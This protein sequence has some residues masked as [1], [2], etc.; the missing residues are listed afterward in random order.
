MKIEPFTI[1]IEESALVDLRRRLE[2]TRFAEDFA[3]AGWEY[4]TNGDYLKELVAY[5]RD[6]YDWRKHEKEMNAW[7]HFRTVI[8][9]MPIHFMHIRGKGPKPI[10]LILSH[11]WPWSFWDFRKVIGPLSDPAAYGGDP[12]DAFDVVVPSL[13]GF[14]FSTPLSKTGINFTTTAD[15]WVK[16]M[17]G[18]GYERFATHGG[19]WGAFISAQLGHKYAD[20]L[21]GTHFTVMTPLDMFS[22]GSV[23]AEDYAPEEMARLQRNQLFMQTGISHLILQSQTPQS[24]A[25]AFNDSPVGLCSWL[26]QKRR[27]WSDCGGNVEACFSKD[28]LLTLVMI[29]WL[30]QCYGTSARYYYE[31]VHHPWQP[32]HDRMP[33]V[34][35]PVGVSVFANELVIQPRRWAERYYNLR[36]WTE[37]PTGGHFAAAEQPEAVIDDV[38]AFYRELR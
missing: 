17:N 25:Y 18:L 36:R 37:F 6:H 30:T 1:A 35:A 5:W 4:G 10:P 8:D 23:P 29:Y 33:V 24:V 20:R 14:G 15:L 3:N 32:S 31:A 16:L 12:A 26:V 9:D 27:S 22:G 13:P 7:P 28:D 21:Y 34:E 19:D 38:R 2:H 11:G